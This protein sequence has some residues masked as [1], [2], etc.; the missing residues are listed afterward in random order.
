MKPVPAAAL[1][2]LTVSTIAAGSLAW[3]QYQRAERLEAQLAGA[4]P[5][6]SHSPVAA[7]HAE[8]DVDEALLL[9]EPGEDEAGSEPATSPTTTP[10]RTRDGRGDPGMR[11]NAMMENPEFAA[12]WQ[13]QQ[14]ARLDDRYAALF[15]K[16]NLHPAQIEQLKALMVDRQAS[17]M[18]VMAAAREE[19]FT[20]RENR[21]ELQALMQQTEKEVEANIRALLGDTAYAQLQQYERTALQRNIVSQ[22]ENRLSYSSTP[23]TAAQSEALVGIL[24]ET[25]GRNR[26]TGSDPNFAMAFPGGPAVNV[27]GRTAITDVAIARAQGLLSPSQLE[28]LRQI[29]AEQQAQQQVSELMRQQFQRE[30]PTAPR[31]PG[32]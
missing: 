32:G 18:D 13:A 8:T 4:P 15:R 3:Q 9:A 23:L 25:S 10:V 30:R 16:L 22:V 31:P 24:A 7:A 26:R 19:G 27:G 17:R 29:Q 12:A 14:K 1:V 2:L 21:D 5:P 6:P 11:L 20:G 28:A